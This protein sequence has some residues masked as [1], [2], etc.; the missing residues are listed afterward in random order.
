[1]N[2]A[3]ETRIEGGDVLV[4]LGTMQNLARAEIRLL[5]G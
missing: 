2:P 5:Q 4:L 3:D 1:V